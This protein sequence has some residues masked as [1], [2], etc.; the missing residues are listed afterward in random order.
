MN[1]TTLPTEI[2]ALQDLVLQEHQRAELYKHRYELLARRAFGQ[3]SEKLKDAPEQQLLFELPT[4]PE[5][6]APVGGPTLSLTS[7]EPFG[8]T[9]TI[10]ISPPVSII[11]RVALALVS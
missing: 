11:E 5:K 4:E 6:P 3:S 2:E 7:S 1:R 10:R 8:L 9:G